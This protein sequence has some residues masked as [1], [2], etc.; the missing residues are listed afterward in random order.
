[1]DHGV[2]ECHALSSFHYSGEAN[3]ACRLSNFPRIMVIDAEVAEAPGCGPGLSRFESVR[4]PL[5]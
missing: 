1:M 5:C 2:A 3:H 4:S